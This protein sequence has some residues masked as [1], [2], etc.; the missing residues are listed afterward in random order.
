MLV[1]G[2]DH[3]TIRAS[4]DTVDECVAFY[5]TI[6]NLRIGFRPPFPVAGFWLYT[7]E[8]P[9]VHLLVDGG[10]DE[11]GAPSCLDH[12]AFSCVNLPLTIR[13]LED[14]KID[15]RSNYLADVDQYQLFVADPAGLSVELNFACEKIGA[16]S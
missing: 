12:I 5:T 10:D 14:L 13:K 8:Q 15:Y 3:Y 16:A 11:C 6:L 4:A 2:L 1:A 7:G 9:I